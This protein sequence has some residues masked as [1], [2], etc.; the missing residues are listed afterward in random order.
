MMYGK[1][2]TQFNDTLQKITIEQIYQW[3]TTSEKL[4]SS[5][6]TL[7][8]IRNLS[9]DSFLK[10]KKELPYFTISVF[11]PPYRKKEHFAYTE[12]LVIDIDSID[13]E[14]IHRLKN[15]LVQDEFV[16]LFFISPSNEGLK[17]VYQF[18]EKVFDPA[19]YV[20]AYKAF[21]QEFSQKYDIHQID[22]KVFDVTRATFLSYDPNAFFN[23]SAKTINIQDYLSVIPPNLLEDYQKEIRNELQSSR[24][25]DNKPLD[26][27]TLQF[28][29][30]KL[31]HKT[32]V[33]K[34]KEIYNPQPLNEITP[35]IVQQLNAQGLTVESI[36]PIQYGKKIRVKINFLWAEVNLFYGKKGFSVIK[37]PKNGSNKE[38]CELVFREISF[39]IQQIQG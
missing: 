38:L 39:I 14:V 28:I 23:S 20:F 3:I 10:A 6:E 27:Q 37:V 12:F 26:E 22:D 32:Y 9:L 4:K 8:N 13:N 2:L 19:Q 29:K 31:Q 11:Y 25:K 24:K 34:A 15:L 16:K 18:S 30:E 1:N 35:Y 7:R 17:I 33:Q 36:E 21:I 5:I